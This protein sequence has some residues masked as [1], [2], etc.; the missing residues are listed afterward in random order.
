MRINPDIINRVKFVTRY[1]GNYLH[2]PENIGDH[3]YE[4]ALHSINIASIVGLDPK[5]LVFRC[6]LHDMS[7]LPNADVPRS[8]KWYNEE[9]AEQINQL[10]DTILMDFVDPELH[11]YII[12]CKDNSL[13]GRVIDILDKLQALIKMR[14]EQKLGNH[15]FDVDINNCTPVIYQLVSK[16]DKSKELTEYIKKVLQG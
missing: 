9:I 1:S 3:S 15:S 6:I 12:N 7:E 2:I 10:Q 14:S 11:K 4:M 16:L 5:E 8:L 13:E